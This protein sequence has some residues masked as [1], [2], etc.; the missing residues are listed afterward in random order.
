MSDGI[1]FFN[2][3]N[4][5][6]LSNQSFPQNMGFG[7]FNFGGFDVLKLN[8][9]NPQN[10]LAQGQ[11]NGDKE[12]N[13]NRNKKK[14]PINKYKKQDDDDATEAGDNTPG[15]NEKTNEDSQNGMVLK[16]SKKIRK[17]TLSKL[18]KRAEKY[19]DENPRMNNKNRKGKMPFNNKFN[20]GK[21]KNKPTAF[22]A[23]A[24]LIAAL[25]PSMF[26]KTKICPH[27]IEGVCKR[28]ES[29]HF[30]HSQS[31]LKEVPNLKKTRVCQLFQIG[32]WI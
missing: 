16:A 22:C 4:L 30:A 31:E 12:N 32:M 14:K 29:C 10:Q 19:F 8:N 2:V 21:G 7:G 20:P 28:G 23:L 11:N 17:H 1:P 3:A 9:I 24:F 6:N 13:N 5:A 27:F 18:Q 26:F 25:S 15:Q